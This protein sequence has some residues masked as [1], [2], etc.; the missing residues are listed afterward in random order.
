MPAPIRLR[1][2]VVPLALA[3]AVATGAFGVFETSISLCD[4]WSYDEVVAPAAAPAGVIAKRALANAPWRFDAR[5]DAPD[6][7][8]YWDRWR[9][10]GD[11]L[12]PLGD[13]AAVCLRYAAWLPGVSAALV[14]TTSAARLAAHVDAVARGPLDDTVIAQLRAG[15]RGR[16]RDWP[17]II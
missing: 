4:G 12:A 5:P 15:S 6:L 17:G 16:D 8:A 11:E 9:T 14:G 2:A 3:A 13:P 1:R 10:R 7:A